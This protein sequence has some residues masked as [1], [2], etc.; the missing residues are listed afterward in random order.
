[1]KVTP[2]LNINI[3]SEKT[4]RVIESANI[5]LLA[6]GTVSLEAML[7]KKAND[8]C[9]YKLSWPTYFIVKLLSKIQYAIIA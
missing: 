2:K 1:M 9:V 3:Y 4:H 7:L 6:S 5:I 8:C